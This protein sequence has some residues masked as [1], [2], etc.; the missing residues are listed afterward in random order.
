[1]SDPALAFPDGFEIASLTQ[2][3]VVAR[4]APTTTPRL[5]GG[6]CYTSAMELPQQ[7]S[8]PQPVALD[9]DGL[10]AAHRRAGFDSVTVTVLDEIDST[11]TWALSNFPAGDRANDGNGL[12]VDPFVVFAENQSGGRGRRGKVWQMRP[13]DDLVFSLGYRMPSGVG[14]EGLSLVTGVAIV[15]A[16]AELGLTSLEIKWPNDIVVGR[17][18]LAGVLI[19][20]SPRPGG[21]FDVVTGVG[22]NFSQIEQDARIGATEAMTVYRS[23]QAVAEATSIEVVRAFDEFARFGFDPFVDRFSKLDALSRERVV[24][25]ST[26]SKGRA[27]RGTA[28]GITRL[29]VLRVRLDDG[30][31]V[32]VNAGD[33]TL[34]AH[35]GTDE[36][37]A[38]SS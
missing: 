34:A 15:D 17:E 7:I 30:N 24:A 21:G 37:G 32:E 26:A 29:G 22:M 4:V 16:L 35:Y 23:R 25:I 8:A 14:L 2:S 19:E 28:C 20:T 38:S 33:V 5:S 27:I 10:Q 36:S 18:K 12:S 9:P 6:G 11:N 31:I 13:F 3:A 1:V